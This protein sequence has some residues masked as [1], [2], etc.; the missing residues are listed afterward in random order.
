ML[1][2][3]RNPASWA[4]VR[5]TVRMFARW[6]ALAR[7]TGCERARAANP[8]QEA[9]QRRRPGVPKTC[10]GDDV[11]LKFEARGGVFAGLSFRARRRR[12]PDQFLRREVP[13]R[14]SGSA[15]LQAILSVDRVG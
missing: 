6:S 7:P 5:T 1:P 14:V 12:V 10:P 11:Q 8:A 3:S 4:R 9:A 13:R 2:G 15:D